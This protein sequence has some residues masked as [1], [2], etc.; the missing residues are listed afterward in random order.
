MPTQEIEVVT[1]EELAGNDLLLARVDSLIDE[2]RTS[3]E[4]LHR[5][6]LEIGVAMLEV[7]KAKAW[8][9]RAKSWDSYVM[10]CGK[11]FGRGRTALYSYVSVAERLLPHMPAAQLVGMGISKAQPLAQYARLHDGKLPENLVES[12]ID[13]SVGL[14]EF[15]A[16][17]AE[18]QNEKPEKGKWFQIPGF[19]V[20]S[21]E[22]EE[23][24]RGLSRATEIEPLPE[25]CPDWLRS[26]IQIQRIVAEFLSTYPCTE[27]GQ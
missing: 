22:Q 27:N 5:D 20:T 26:K 10:D 1:R 21:E 17:V 7:Q 12:A 15:K 23:I 9:S 4:K 3:E 16:T 8:L 14:E 2:A 25:I 13:P 19:F 11:R 6:F 18:A 24:E